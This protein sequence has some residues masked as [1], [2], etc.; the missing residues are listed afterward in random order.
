MVCHERGTS[1]PYPKDQKD[2]KGN[3]D[4]LRAK[5]AYNTEALF[6]WT[7]ILTGA[8]SLSVL[9][10][11]LRMIVRSRKRHH[12]LKALL[13][14]QRSSWQKERSQN[15]AKLSEL[16]RTIQTLQQ[17]E[18]ERQ[19]REDRRQRQEEK[20][21][22]A[23]FRSLRDGQREL[24]II[25]GLSGLDFSYPFF[26]SGWTIDGFM[27]LRVLE[28][29]ET[30]RPRVILELGSGASTVM[31]QAILKKLN[32]DARHVAIDHDET[33][34]NATRQRLQQNGFQDKVELWHCPL[35]TREAGGPAWYSNVENRL[36]GSKLDLVL[37]DGPPGDLHP[38]SRKPALYA[39]RSYLNQGA[40]VLLDD[41]EREEEHAIM[42]AWK[43]SFPEME[44]RG[45]ARGKGYAE[46]T[47][48]VH[49]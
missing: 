22:N 39:L 17:Q 7:L 47:A 48:P 44:H 15:N 42:E 32:L 37:V 5:T 33:Y 31:I 46:F 35:E 29:I 3:A 8:S 27:A 43:E 4:C 49:A 14:R 34:L 16:L 23:D 19:Q 26:L 6:P 10:L 9:A 11:Q 18:E 36:Q 38:E 24:A 12:E 20:Q 45:S 1:L 2:Q 41:A 30:K 13:E 21:R 40:V 28:L 25:H